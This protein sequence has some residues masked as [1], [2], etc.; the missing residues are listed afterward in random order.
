MKS[1][2]QIVEQYASSLYAQGV[3]TFVHYDDFVVTI[4]ILSGTLFSLGNYHV[5]VDYAKDTA[6]LSEF[7]PFESKTAFEARSQIS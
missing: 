7:K 2:R 3:M 5:V 4:D 6:Y 1:C